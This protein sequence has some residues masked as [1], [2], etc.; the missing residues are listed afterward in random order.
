MRNFNNAY[1]S[2]KVYSDSDQSGSDN[3]NNYSENP[4]K[5]AKAGR[6]FN[7]DPKSAN[8][9]K[10]AE[11]EGHSDKQLDKYINS[12]LTTYT[13]GYIPI[14]D[15]FSLAKASAII[16]TSNNNF[17]TL[18]IPCITSKQMRVVIYNK[19]MTEINKKFKK[20]YINLWGPHYPSSL[21]RNTYVRI[22]I[23]TKTKKSWVLYLYSK[24][25]FVNAFQKWLPII[26]V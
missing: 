21:S 17:D 22:L 15:H 23:N 13:K 7:N 24:N 18:C 4:K 19:P 6:H 20:V 3:D 8:P 26:E 9:E 5:S 11:I 2:T 10:L 14:L 12:H 25:K 16:A 1:D